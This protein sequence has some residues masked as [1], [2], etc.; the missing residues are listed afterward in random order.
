MI[1]VVLMFI[2]ENREVTNSPIGE[3]DLNNKARTPGN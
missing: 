2:L 1:S 3:H